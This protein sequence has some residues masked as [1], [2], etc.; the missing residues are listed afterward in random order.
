MSYKVYRSHLVSVSAILTL[1]TS[2]SVCVALT[3]FALARLNY[4]KWRVLEEWNVLLFLH[5]L[6]TTKVAEFYFQHTI[7]SWHLPDE[8][9]MELV[10]TIYGPEHVGLYGGVLILTA[11]EFD[12]SGCLVICTENGL[13][14][15]LEQVDIVIEG[16]A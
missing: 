12:H 5:R 9:R 11:I 13:I 3:Q 16:L 4:D 2:V 1:L 15:S 8:Q 6:V 14:V 10:F 7:C